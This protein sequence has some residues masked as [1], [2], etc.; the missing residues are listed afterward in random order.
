MHM[1]FALNTSVAMFSLELPEMTI[2][3]DLIEL[4]LNLIQL[5][6]QRHWSYYRV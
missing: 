2:I 1:T 6:P 3:T 4:N 5:C